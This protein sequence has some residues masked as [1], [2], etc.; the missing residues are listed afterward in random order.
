M[1]LL[2]VTLSGIK[3]YTKPQSFNFEDSTSINTLSGRNGAGK[4]T[5]FAAV[6]QVQKAFF[7]TRMQ[8]VVTSAEYEKL[9][10]KLGQELYNSSFEKGS[11][12]EVT[13]EFDKKDRALI[14]PSNVF[15]ENFKLY[16]PE[17]LEENHT[18]KVTAKLKVHGILQNT[19]QW[20]IFLDDR[21]NAILGAFWNLENPRNVVA[22]INSSKNIVEQDVMFDN[23]KLRPSRKPVNSIS[24]VVYFAIEPESAFEKLYELMVND[25]LYEKMNPVNRKTSSPRNDIYYHVTKVLFD[26]LS[27]HLMLKNLSFVQKEDQF[28]ITAQQRIVGKSS[29]YD[30]R[31]FSAGEKLLWYSLLFIN[32]TKSMGILIIDEPENHLHEELASK[33]VALLQGLVEA[34]DYK[35]FINTLGNRNNVR[36]PSLEK[37]L[38]KEYVFFRLSQVFLLTHS[39]SLI[40]QNFTNG[41]NFALQ[42]NTVSVIDYESCERVL[43]DIGLSYVNDKVLFVE[44]QTDVVLLE[45]VV[46]QYNI[47]VKELDNCNE[48]IKVFKSVK[49]IKDLLKDPIF[50]FMIDRDTRSN[51]EIEKLRN[52]DEEY[53]E[54]HFIILDKHELENYYLEPS[55]L[56]EALKTFEHP[57]DL[58]YQAPSLQNIE[59]IIFEVANLKLDDTK[60]KYLNYNLNNTIGK[61]NSLIKRRDLKVDTIQNH[62]QHI[63]E[64][65]SGENFEKIKRELI[66]HF[67]AMEQSFSESNWR[68]NWRELMDGKSVYS[69]VINRLSQGCPGDENSL[70]RRV[71]EILLSSRDTEFKRLTNQIFRMFNIVEGPIRDTTFE[72]TI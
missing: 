3:K 13:F 4:T 46:G 72:E 5:I 20:S 28:V 29:A 43:R 48:I 12:I 58:V 63:E 55:V 71:T 27:P 30:M 32:Y 22:F 35:K 21:D 66:E 25:Y 33:L 18:C 19:A 47:K 70:K 60:R 59:E 37:E 26:Y 50:V 40:Y 2:N 69:L 11:Y 8:N 16:W 9:S 57:T 34:E 51:E 1:R 42:N 39:K 65:L 64:I 44:G 67:E 6:M 7:I 23:L 10:T 14:A 62:E 56:E 31:G 45:K 17:D 54:K 36:L 41:K 52:E 24:S 53:F 49:Q 15:D 38:L 61:M 68:S